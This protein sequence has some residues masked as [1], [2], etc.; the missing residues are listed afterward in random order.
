MTCLFRITLR[1]FSFK[2]SI[3]YDAF[4]QPEH[5]LRFY[6]LPICKPAHVQTHEPYFLTCEDVILNGAIR[7]DVDSALL[8]F[9]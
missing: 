7:S 1:A 9:H 3:M 6:A 5:L 2:A 8:S 4:Y